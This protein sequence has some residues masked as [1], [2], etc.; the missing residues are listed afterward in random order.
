MSQGTTL[1]DSHRQSDMSGIANH[2]GMFGIWANGGA[3]GSAN[4]ANTPDNGIDFSNTVLNSC[5]RP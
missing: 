3:F 4:T 2:F 5:M 1:M